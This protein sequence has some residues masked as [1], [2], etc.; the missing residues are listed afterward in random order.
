[1]M[2]LRIS[3]IH[4]S[5]DQSLGVFQKLSAN[6]LG[7][8]FTGYE[9]H[10]THLTCSS[11]SQ[12]CVQKSRHQG[13]Q[14]VNVMTSR[15]EHHFTVFIRDILQNVLQFFWTSSPTSSLSHY[16]YMQEFKYVN[17]T[18]NII[19]TIF[20]FVLNITNFHYHT[21]KGPHNRSFIFPSIIP[22]MF[23]KKKVSLTSHCCFSLSLIHGR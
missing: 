14:A 18:F 23:N 16:Y 2:Q 9:N 5:I 12:Y 3:C 10:C 19:H 22:T 7:Q 11:L 13:D 6:T 8:L 17:I 1:M 21:M 20:K 4:V 15:G